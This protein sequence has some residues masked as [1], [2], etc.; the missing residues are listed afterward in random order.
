M[1]LYKVPIKSHYDENEC[2]QLSFGIRTKFRTQVTYPNILP[3]LYVSFKV[4]MIIVESEDFHFYTAKGIS[5]NKI[6]RFDGATVYLSES[7]LDD[8]YFIGIEEREIQQY[9][10]RRKLN[11][12]IDKM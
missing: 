8:E 5:S 4:L 1:P 9:I 3:A 10:R 2:K 11:K 6:G 7:L 12:I